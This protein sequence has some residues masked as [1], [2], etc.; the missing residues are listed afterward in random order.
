MNDKIEIKAP[1]NS[2]MIN[3]KNSGEV[4]VNNT[5]I[6][7]KIK[8]NLIRL[9]ESYI[10]NTE[11]KA[12]AYFSWIKHILTIAVGVLAFG[13]AMHKDFFTDSFTCCLCLVLAI[14]FLVFTI[15]NGLLSLM[16]EAAFY[17]TKCRNDLGDIENQERN[18]KS[19]VK[20]RHHPY[21]RPQYEQ[22]ANKS[23]FCF[24]MAMLALLLYMFGTLIVNIVYKFYN[25]K[26]ITEIITC[27]VFGIFFGLASW[28]VS[29]KIKVVG[30]KWKS[31]DA[32][33]HALQSAF[34][35]IEE[36]KSPKKQEDAKDRDSESSGMKDK[37]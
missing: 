20:T 1:N 22:L 10:S 14:V 29:K 11:K 3:G 26:L 8:Q 33:R 16:G 15:Y 37:K 4:N 21:V 30:F 24:S 7:A 35:K 32:F 13:S 5:N 2:G 6:E 28:H 36:L 19:S 17:D 12:V 25:N 9:E 34:N 27:S 18:K 23:L 31:I